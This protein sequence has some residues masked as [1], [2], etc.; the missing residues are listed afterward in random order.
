L[1]EFIGYTLHRTRLEPCVTFAALYLLRRLKTFYPE[2][3]SFAGEK[4]FLISF[5][6]AQKILI[7][8][9]YGNRAFATIAQ[10]IMDLK[11]INTWERE[12]YDDL[13]WCLAV[14]PKELETFTR[15]LR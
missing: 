1:S 5:I 13:N 15:S 3:V 2:A 11:E 7:D 4:L 14:D 12:L 6:A 9:P 10:D 8:G